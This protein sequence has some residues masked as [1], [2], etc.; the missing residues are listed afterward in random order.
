MPPPTHTISTV[1]PLRGTPS[2]SSVS[3]PLYLASWISCLVPPDIDELVTH[4]LHPVVPPPTRPLFLPLP[5]PLLLRI[6]FFLPLSPWV[7]WD[8]CLGLISGVWPLCGPPP[9]GKFNILCTIS[10]SCSYGVPLPLAVGDVLSP[11]LRPVFCSLRLPC[12][13]APRSFLI[14]PL[15]VSSLLL[16]LPSFQIFLVF[17]SSGQLGISPFSPYFCRPCVVGA[18]CCPGVLPPLPPS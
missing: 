9:G 5:L 3:S 16:P 11:S 12:L 7:G 8:G 18:R 1:I 6:L 15:D 17:W 2:S 13:V 14:L 4:T 10:R